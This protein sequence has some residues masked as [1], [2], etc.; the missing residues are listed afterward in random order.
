MRLYIIRHADPD[1]EKGTI[2]EHGH[3]ESAA[4]AQRMQYEC[5]DQIYCSTMQ[6]A[7]DT[8]S[9]TQKCTGIEPIMCDWMREVE[10]ADTIDDYTNPWDLPG[11]LLLNEPDLP[12]EEN[13]TRNPF[14]DGEYVS[15]DLKTRIHAMEQFLSQLGYERDGKH[16]I[17]TKE[18]HTKV[19][20][21]CHAGFGN[22]MISYLLNIPLTLQW[23]G[24]WLAPTS[25]TTIL[26]SKRNGRIVV[27]RCIALGDTSHLYKNELTIKPRGLK[28]DF[29]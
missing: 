16:F 21:F 18:N 14:F 7:I 13:W 23:A 3:L 5:I 2:T 15:R 20:M 29:I 22:A 27:P 9:Y 12:N 4:L 11:D 1:Y 25:V 28:G 6:R 17:E 8:M 19:A 24:F 26:F 10:W